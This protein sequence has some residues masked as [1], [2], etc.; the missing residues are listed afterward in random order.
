M[1]PSKNHRKLE[2]RKERVRE[3]TTVEQQQVVGG[4]KD[5]INPDDA[6]DTSRCVTTAA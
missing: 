3:L 4:A 5:V 1:K 6:N 2:L